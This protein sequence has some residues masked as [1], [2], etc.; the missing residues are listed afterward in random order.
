[1]EAKGL[2]PVLNVSDLAGT[3]AW[4]AKCTTLCCDVSMP[5]RLLWYCLLC[6]VVGLADAQH[7]DQVHKPASL[8]IKAGK[9]LDVRK[10]TYIDNVAIWI[11][12]DRIKEVDSISQVAHAP[13]GIQV[14]DL[15]RLTLMPGLID[16]HTHL[17][18]RFDDT[19]EG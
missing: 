19:P 16:C 10:G 1:M 4:F 15:S 6:V 14:I 18:D 9:L 7:E 3:F 12:E 17:M 2:T 5:R 13:R 8:L 11:E